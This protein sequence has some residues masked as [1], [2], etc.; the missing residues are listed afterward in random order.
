MARFPGVKS[1]HRRALTRCLATYAA[2]GWSGF[3]PETCRDRL[4]L[5]P[6]NVAPWLWGWPDRFLDRMEAAGSE[7]YLLAPMRRG[8]GFSEGIDSPALL[9]RLPPGYSGGIWTDAIDLIAPAL[10]RVLTE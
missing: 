7:V 4:I 6:L 3:V 5:V 8:Q 9:E 1:I 2:I 10:D